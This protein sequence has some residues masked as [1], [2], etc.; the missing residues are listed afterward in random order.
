MRCRNT[1]IQLV[2]FCQQVHSALE[3]ITKNEC[4]AEIL[5]VEGNNVA[6][7]NDYESDSSQVSGVTSQTVNLWTVSDR[8]LFFFV[9]SQGMWELEPR[10]LV[11]ADSGR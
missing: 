11:S 5:T 6:Y 3:N 10:N 1:N 2:C 9:S 4:P 7:F 8:S